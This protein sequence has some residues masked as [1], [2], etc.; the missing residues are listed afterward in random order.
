METTKRDF[1]GEFC[2]AI[3]T[4]EGGVGDLNHRNNNP[5]NC[6]YFSGGYLPIYGVVK[7]DKNGFAIFKDWDT[8]MLY[9]E[10]MIKYKAIKRPTQTITQFMSIYAPFSDGNN[11]VMY[12]DFIGKQLGVNPD[13]FTMGQVIA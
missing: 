7:Q 5:G 9:L 10:N 8:G 11:P 1:L 4:Y 2:N 6:R 3:S 12:A 13:I